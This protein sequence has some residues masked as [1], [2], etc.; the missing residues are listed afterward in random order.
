[1]YNYCCI[2]IR[3]NLYHGIMATSNHLNH[4]P[5]YPIRVVAERTGLTPAAI[6]AWERRYGVVAPSRS[7]GAQRLYTDADV[8]RLRLVTQ[9][10]A[11]G[12]SLADLS[13]R[14]TAVLARLS[15]EAVTTTPTAQIPEPTNQRRATIDRLLDGARKLNPGALRADLMQIVLDLGPIPAMDEIVSPFLVRIGEAWACGDVSIAQ[16]HVASSVVRDV[17]GWV[18]QSAIPSAEAPT[19][20]ATTIAGEGHEFG[21]MM[22]ATVAAVAGWR[23][24]YLGANTPAPDLA[25]AAR[26]SNAKVIVL[27]IVGEEGAENVKAEANALRKA[28]GSRSKVVAG[29]AA[30]SDHRLT[31]KRARVDILDSRADLRRLLNT[32]WTRDS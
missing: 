4:S 8:E 11:E 24:L 12:Y 22:A 30:A 18:L 9:L 17:L 1:L 15:S 7:E 28:V 20:I 21:A 29:G 23:V 19:L 31:L 14:S 27:G 5:R 3:H 32:L 6:R 25:R 2:I 13:K 26:S 16:E 10:S